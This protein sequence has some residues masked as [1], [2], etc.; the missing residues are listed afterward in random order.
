[1]SS[2]PYQSSG[3]GV[4]VMKS[5]SAG[6]EDGAPTV[7][8][9]ASPSTVAPSFSTANAVLAPLSALPSTRRLD[10]PNTAAFR[11][12]ASLLPTLTTAPDSS[13]GVLSDPRP[14]SRHEASALAPGLALPGVPSLPSHLAVVVAVVVLITLLSHS[15]RQTLRP[16]DEWKARETTNLRAVPA[17][18]RKRFPSDAA[19]AI[20]QWFGS[21]ASQFCV[22]QKASPKSSSQHRFFRAS[23]LRQDHEMNLPSLLRS[24]PSLAPQRL[25]LGVPLARSIPSPDA[26]ASPS[27]P[28]SNLPHWTDSFVRA[29]V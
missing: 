1:M 15:A 22:T 6:G 17:S 7:A 14:S 13:P 19:S 26:D 10:A 20:N 16:M 27:F 8:V 11:T 2:N 12:N 24:P 9:V 29:L 5:S 28:S 25:C 18:A 4:F 23:G 21:T 3:S